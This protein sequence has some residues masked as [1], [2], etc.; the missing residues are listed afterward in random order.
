MKA[1]T[2]AMVLSVAAASFMGRLDTYIVNISLPTIA[3]YFH[4][5]LGTVSQVILAYLLAVAAVMPAAGNLG[6]RIGFRRMLAAGYILFSTS[7]LFCGAARSIHWII[8]ARFVQGLGGALLIIMAAAIVTRRTERDELGSAMSV[9]NVAGALGVLLGA[10][11]GGIL[12]G[13]VSWRWIFFIN[14]PVGA[15]ALAMAWRLI[16][17]DEAQ[18]E[19]RPFDWLGCGLSTAALLLIV[20]SL[21]MFRSSGHNLRGA[22]ALLAG[23]GLLAA[24]V[25]WEAR[26]AHPL[27]DLGIFRSRAFSLGMAAKFLVFAQMAAHGFLIPFYLDWTRGLSAQASGGV[28][29]VFP[30]ATILA[31]PLAGRL[32]DR[33]HPSRVALL[34]MLSAT[35]ASVFFAAALSAPGLWPA[36]TYLAW[37]GFSFG[38]FL[39][40]NGKMVLS[41]A[42]R[43]RQGAAASVFHTGGN[44]GMALGVCLAALLFSL[45]LPPGVSPAK[46]ALAPHLLATATG[47]AFAGVY[48]FNALCCA[49]A[50]LCQFLVLKAPR[51]KPEAPSR[52]KA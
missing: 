39:S 36:V 45:C 38:M 48:L 46:H 42:P 29:A 24:F 19:K 32:A 5:G 3:A 8:A 41:S 13:L 26:H 23:T 20:L 1:R 49:A 30:V 43:D 31:A 50:A 28:V 51:P 37:M 6:D 7:S 14:L 9:L 12:S 21:G 34:A 33:F 10:P 40:P 15:A 22:L 35:L 44:V 27:L 25:L 2:M 18:S 52:A 16:P 17:P 47:P 4:A 11:L